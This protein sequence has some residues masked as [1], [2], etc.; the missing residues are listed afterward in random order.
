MSLIFVVILCALE[1]L[2]IFGPIDTLEISLSLSFSLEF[3]IEVH[4]SLVYRG[5]FDF[6]WDFLHL[7]VS[8]HS[9]FLFS[10]VDRKDPLF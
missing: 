5:V 6:R 3:V 1:C 8:F 7:G 4:V 2:F 9:I 10:L